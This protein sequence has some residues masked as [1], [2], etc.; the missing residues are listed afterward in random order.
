MY[1]PR[2]TLVTALTPESFGRVEPPSGILT[3]AALLRPIYEVRIIELNLIWNETCR[4]SERFLKMAT[5][6]I[7]ETGSEI[8]GFSSICGTYPTTVRLASH[9]SQL[10]PRS[11]IVFGGPHASV[12]DVATL[13]AFP[14]V[15]AIVRGEAEQTFRARHQKP[16]CHHYVEPRRT[17]YA[18]LRSA[19][20]H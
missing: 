13:G 20:R 3:L 1:S 19:S 11:R 18:G 15:D 4:S 16:E 17:A 9:V 5:D 2:V 14:F 8:V 10:L 6:A 12:V 7:A